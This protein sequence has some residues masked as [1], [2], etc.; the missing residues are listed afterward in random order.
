MSARLCVHILRARIFQPLIR[1]INHSFM[2]E[3]PDLRLRTNTNDSLPLPHSDHINQRQTKRARK[4]NGV[5]TSSTPLSAHF[6]ATHFFS[7]LL[8]RPPKRPTWMRTN[9][10]PSLVRPKVDIILSIY[11][12]CR[13]R[14]SGSVHGDRRASNLLL[15]LLLR[16]YTHECIG[17]VQPYIYGTMHSMRARAHKMHSHRHTA[18]RP[19][20]AHTNTTL[21]QTHKSCSTLFGV[22]G[23]ARE[24]AATPCCCCCKRTSASSVRVRVSIA[25]NLCIHCER[26]H[27]SNGW[28]LMV[29]GW[30][31]AELSGSA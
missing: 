18:D 12:M 28:R 25:A 15:L 7:V 27:H 9:G 31:A 21:S 16:T 8:A 26:V 23:R 13:V 10:L 4:R 29:D 20:H 5:P 6:R 14:C 2:S 30:M 19:P 11:Q 17:D 3:V 22:C 1:A 24:P